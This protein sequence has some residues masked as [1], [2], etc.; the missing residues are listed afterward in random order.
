MVDLSQVFTVGALLWTFRAL[1]VTAGT[2]VLLDFFAH[3]TSPVESPPYNRVVNARA[4][5]FVS[6]GAIIGGVALIYF[7]IDY[8]SPF[9]PFAPRVASLVMWALL[10]LALVARA[11]S[12]AEQPWLIYVAALLIVVGGRTVIALG[13]GPVA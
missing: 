11:G 1:A 8:L 9:A 12:R 6:L 4:W 10:S 5:A 3:A 13:G 7:D 2:F